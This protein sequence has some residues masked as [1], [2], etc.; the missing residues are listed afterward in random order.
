MD[1][2]EEKAA[3]RSRWKKNQAYNYSKSKYRKKGLA[4]GNDNKRN[5]EAFAVEPQQ[6]AAALQEVAEQSFQPGQ[7]SSDEDNYS[8]EEGSGGDYEEWLTMYP[9][10]PVAVLMRKRLAL[11]D[12]DLL[13]FLGKKDSS[14]SILKKEVLDTRI[15]LDDLEKVIGSIPM[16]AALDIGAELQELMFGDALQRPPERHVNV[17][18]VDSDVPQQRE[19]LGHHDDTVPIATTEKLELETADEIDKEM[20]SILRRD[21]K[22]RGNVDDILRQTTA[23][24]QTVP[25]AAHLEADDQELDDF[26]DSLT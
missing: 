20:E 22:Y 17:L 24:R 1:A 3:A 6:S 15:N 11:P 5:T 10:E 26:L 12:G 21:E 7:S 4:S 23:S 2:R 8:D 13:Q 25:A 16:V 19:E 14:A 18:N 9:A